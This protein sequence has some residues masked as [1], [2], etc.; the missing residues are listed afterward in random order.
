MKFSLLSDALNNKQIIELDR[1]T[2]KPDTR[3]LIG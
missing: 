2:T 3:K 1:G